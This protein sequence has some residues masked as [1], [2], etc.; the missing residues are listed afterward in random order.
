MRR[1]LALLLCVLMLG[2]HIPIGVAD[3]EPVVEETVYDYEITVFVD[4]EASGTVTGDGPCNHGDTVT[5]TAT[6]NEGYTFVAWYDPDDPNTP[7]SSA[8]T[9]SFTAESDRTLIARF[10]SGYAVTVVNGTG[11][12]DYAAGATVSISADDPAQGQQF[13]E[14][15]SN[16]GVTF[17]DAAS[18]QTTF[19]MPEKAVTVTANFEDV[20]PTAYTVTVVNGTGDGSYEAGETVSIRADVPAEGMHFKEWIGTDDLTFISG[21][22]S[23]TRAA[24]IMP[25]RNVTVRAAYV[26]NSSNHSYHSYEDTFPLTVIYGTGSG[27]YEADATVIIRADAPAAGKRFKEWRSTDGVVFINAT[28]AETIIIMP[29]N[30]A[31]VTAIY[32][33]AYSYSDKPLHIYKTYILTVENGTGSGDYQAGVTV[34]I[35][36]DA[37]GEG[38]RF[39]AWTGADDLTFISGS[40]DSAEASFIMPARRFTLTATYEPIPPTYTATVENGTG[41]GDYEAGDTVSIKADAPAEGKQ[42]LK[43]TGADG[44]TFT[45][46]SADSAEA[47]FTMPEKAVTL[48][49]TYEDIPVTKYTV[50]VKHGT[51][52]GSY[53]AGE[54]VTISPVRPVK[55]ARFKKWTQA[56]GLTFTTGSPL[57]ANAAFIMPAHN[58]ELKATFDITAEDAYTVTV[59]NGTG[60]SFYFSGD[61][62]TISADAPAEGKRFKA[63]TGA[64]DLTFTIGSAESAEAAFT[65]PACDVRLTATYEDIPGTKYTVT[66]ENGTGGGEYEAG[67]TVSIKAD[68]PAEGK[69]FLKWTGADG[70]TF[71]TGSAFRAE[72]A[73]TMPARNVT[74][75][76]TY[77][78]IPAARYVV[79]VQGG[80][81]G[82]VFEAGDTVSISADA[83]SKGQ[84]FKAWIGAD[85]LTFTMGSATTADATFTMPAKD[86]TVAPI[87]EDVPTFAVTVE[88]G[89]GRGSYQVGETVSISADA[90]SEGQRFKEWTGV[91]GLTFTKGSAV[92]AEASFIMPARNVD[93]TATYEIFYSSSHR[94]TVEK[95]TGSGEYQAG[96]IVSIKADAPDKGMQFKGWTGTDGLTFT[97]GS[98]ATAE[99][100]FIMPDQFVTV[101]ATYEAISATKYAVTVTNGTGDGSYEAGATVTLTASVPVG[102]K[103]V[104]WTANG[105]DD[106]E[107]TDR[108]AKRTTFIMPAH[109]VEVVALNMTNLFDAA[110]PKNI[111]VFGGNKTAFGKTANLL[112]EEEQ[113][114]LKAALQNAVDNIDE[115]I[116]QAENQSALTA[117][118]AAGLVEQDEDGNIPEN[119]QVEI[120]REFHTEVTAQGLTKETKPDGTE[121]KK[122]KLDISAN[123]NLVASV[124]G[125][126]AQ[127]PV[128][129]GNPATI[130][131]PVALS[132]DLPDDFVD[133]NQNFAYV[134]HQHGGRKYTYRG[135][136]GPKTDGKRTMN[137]RSM[138]LSPF[139]FTTELMAA[140]IT[141][142]VDGVPMELYY[143]TLQEAVEEAE[144]QGVITLVEPA[145]ENITL[146]QGKTFT[147]VLAPEV[148]AADVRLT[149]DGEAVTFKDGR[150]VLAAGGN[151]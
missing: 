28:S 62:V 46:G 12:G 97:M 18:A 132:V 34:T 126:N 110:H 81:G 10:Q 21:D 140:M 89:T 78:D 24:F 41:S 57:S 44:L 101:R 11:G 103:F 142:D 59:E 50:S 102:K 99:A 14:W 87:Y 51:G 53:A 25:A 47:A 124:V 121:V 138:G 111:E 5:L 43:W 73:F 30:A 40:A 137:F 128:S 48:T 76:A 91:D 23:S 88:N 33:D 147:L 149:V 54:T 84:Q 13:K 119:S 123:Y 45:T 107:F 74:L 71:T 96:T 105:D 15:T 37:P 130:D 95:G 116:K 26:P 58:V 2:A 49:A 3:S 145:A 113:R 94:L 120:T 104:G 127:I 66:V 83:P 19:T 7:L 114:M 131:K 72:A 143:A 4:P 63:W 92:T 36:A 148:N 22:A 64:D 60:T 77:E 86:V 125:S 39:K 129:I 106:V 118:I 136:L 65:M 135:E 141:I 144:D 6:A 31:T 32:E 139:E 16:D 151:S 52:S 93:L 100:S 70:L 42:F 79:I 146:P 9:L 109:D 133:E 1:F 55:L 29:E 38:I 61:T 17:A 82:G 68:A 67:A 122:L 134:N 20:P 85:D 112:T 80:T 35:R 117:L 75:T 150:A 8:T 56:E 27:D 98:A 115:K 90:S 69:Q 108:N